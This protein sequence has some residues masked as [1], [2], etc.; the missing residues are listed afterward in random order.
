M[1]IEASSTALN[2]L[3]IYADDRL[4]KKGIY[5]F[6]EK[7]DIGHSAYGEFL[8][9][10]GRSKNQIDKFILKNF[11]SLTP[12]MYNQLLRAMDR[13]VNYMAHRLAG[14]HLIA[15]FPI[16]DLSKVA[17]FLEHVLLSDAF[18]PMG[19]PILPEKIV[20][21]YGLTKYC[22]RLNNNWNFVNAFDILTGTISIHR[23]SVELLSAIK[24]CKSIDS[25]EEIAKELGIGAME[26]CIAISRANPFLLVGAITQLASSIIAFAN[27]SNN[28][29]FR[30]VLEEYSINFELKVL[31]L[32]E[33]LMSYS[34]ENELNELSLEN[35][36]GR[37]DIEIDT[38]QF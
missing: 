25:F 31:S 23:S 22:S 28:V 35:E 19:L 5:Y 11:D 33:E 17:D 24:G 8:D 38:K 36:L 12:Q 20:T 16:N 13:E 6:M 34:L 37:N 4:R 15:D 14:H 7:H 1:F 3:N 9:V 18:T 30:K 26:L 29:Y 10:L 2:Y 27:D 21:D 32:E